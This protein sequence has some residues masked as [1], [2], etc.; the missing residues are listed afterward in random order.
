MMLAPG[1]RGT[2]CKRNRLEVEAGLPGV[3]GVIR[4]NRVLANFCGRLAD[5]VY[6]P[7]GVA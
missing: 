4:V 6:P 2:T 5:A 1:Q 3:D 7:A